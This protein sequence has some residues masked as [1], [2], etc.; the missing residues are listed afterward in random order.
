MY[1]QK[2]L[3]GL[4]KATA[5]LVIFYQIVIDITRT[6]Q[7]IAYNASYYHSYDGLDVMDVIR[8]IFFYHYGV[9]LLIAAIVFLGYNGRKPLALIGG[10]LLLFESLINLGWH[11]A[12]K[13]LANAGNFEFISHS[14]L[15][16]TRGISVLFVAALILIAIYCR[17]KGMIVM[18][19][20]IAIQQLV[21]WPV[22]SYFVNHMQPDFNVWL[23]INWVITW[24]GSIFEVIY[25][26]MWSK[27]AK[28]A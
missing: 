11:I 16:F 24:L 8:D 6:W 19:I 2:G 14:S 17:H 4:L 22:F 12:Y 26:F 21:F 10:L 5:L 1:R 9:L 13:I 18:A 15:W 27:N 23:P 3:P 28:I 7:L 25:L 20:L